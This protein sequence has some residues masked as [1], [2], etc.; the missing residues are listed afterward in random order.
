M[1]LQ[2]RMDAFALA[3]LKAD[4]EMWGA[5]KRLV[6]QVDRDIIA[7]WSQDDTIK[8]A[9]LR[10]AREAVGCILPAVEQ[11]I[12]DASEVVEEEKHVAIAARSTSDDGIGSGDLSI[13]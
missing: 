13:A 9:W 4:E 3:R 5:L 2:Q 12:R 11:S 6:E 7:K 10:G 8:K 1:T